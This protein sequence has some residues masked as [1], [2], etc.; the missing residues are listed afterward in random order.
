[1]HKYKKLMVAGVAAL[2]L[3]TTQAAPASAATVGAGVFTGSATL[4]DAG[5]AGL[6]YPVSPACGTPIG[7]CPN[8]NGT[9]TLDINGGVGVATDGT[10]AG[11]AAGTMDGTVSGKVGKNLLGNGVGAFCGVSGGSDG[12]GSVIVDTASTSV[13]GIEWVTSAATLIVFENLLTKTS[14]PNMVG[15]ASAIPPAPLPGA[16]SCLNNSAKTFTVVGAAVLAG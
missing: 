7:V 8:E 14:G 11:T 3:L 2:G 13:N 4:V 6:S 12:A 10:A 5:G 9:W 1:V 15:V 16:D